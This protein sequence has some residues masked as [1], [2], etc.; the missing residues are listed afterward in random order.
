MFGMCRRDAGE[1]LVDQL[2]S[3]VVVN[4][5][6]GE[7]QAAVNWSDQHLEQQ[8]GVNVGAAAR[9]MTAWLDLTAVSAQTV[10]SVLDGETAARA[11]APVRY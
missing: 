10:G 5:L 6:T 3:E 9:L 2:L 8:P 11:P 4:R 7:Q 1:S